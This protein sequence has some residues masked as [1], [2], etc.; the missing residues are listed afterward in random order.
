[1]F[2]LKNMK[3]YKSHMRDLVSYSKA[4]FSQI[5]QEFTSLQKN[6]VLLHGNFLQ[7]PPGFG[8][9]NEG[10]ADLYST[11]YSNYYH[12]ITTIYTVLKAKQDHN[13]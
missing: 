12:I 11:T 9:G 13:C 7:V 5:P 1:M 6:P 2:S 4:I 8:P 3:Q 10:F